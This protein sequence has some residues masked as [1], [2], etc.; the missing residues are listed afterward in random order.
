MLKAVIILFLSY[1]ILE[2]NCTTHLTNYNYTYI[3][4]IMFFKISSVFIV[5][6]HDSIKFSEIKRMKTNGI[7]N[8]F[9]EYEIQNIN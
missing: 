4:I 5:A 7:W 1:Q 6:K 9:N 3:S 8:E 2:E